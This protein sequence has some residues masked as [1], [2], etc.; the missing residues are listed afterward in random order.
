MFFLKFVFV[1]GLFLILRV[2]RFVSRLNSFGKRNKSK[3]FKEGDLIIYKSKAIRKTSKIKA[4]TID[5]EEIK[6]G[7]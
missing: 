6:E 7:N 5:F 4:E 1:L 3:T 2:Y